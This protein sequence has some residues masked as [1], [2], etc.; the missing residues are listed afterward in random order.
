MV[1]RLKGSCANLGAKRMIACCTEFE[2]KGMMGTGARA[3][4]IL[5]KLKEEFQRVR[6]EVDMLTAHG[7]E[8]NESS[9]T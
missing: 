4:A 3:E 1:Q 9:Q 8:Q 7:E 6:K 5:I 2:E